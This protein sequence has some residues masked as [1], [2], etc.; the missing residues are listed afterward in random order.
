MALLGNSGARGKIIHKKPE[1][2]NPTVPLK[3]KNKFDIKVLL[4]YSLCSRAT[5]NPSIW[6]KCFPGW[7]FPQQNSILVFN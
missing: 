6:R 4:S 5:V 3:R 7:W 2:N 1:E